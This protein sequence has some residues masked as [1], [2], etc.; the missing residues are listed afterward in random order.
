M[1][2]VPKFII[3]WIMIVLLLVLK[4]FVSS[5]PF[6]LCR[7]P[8]IYV[9]LHHKGQAEYHFIMFTLCSRTNGCFQCTII[10]SLL[11]ELLFMLWHSAKFYCLELYLSCLCLRVLWSQLQMIYLYLIKFVLAKVTSKIIVCYHLPTRGRAG[12]KLGDDDTSQT[13]L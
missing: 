3:D 13:Y 5:H 10:H 12:V 6:E 7:C 4:L 2:I 9:L 1:C 11:F 8:S